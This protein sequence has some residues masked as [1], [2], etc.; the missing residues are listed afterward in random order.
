[1]SSNGV[2]WL[3]ASRPAKMGANWKLRDIAITVSGGQRREV[4][5]FIQLDEC[6][7]MLHV[8]AD[9]VKLELTGLGLG[10]VGGWTFK[11]VE[12]GAVACCTDCNVVCRQL[13]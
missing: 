12:E 3:E 2:G 10:L 13:T 1:M 11:K 6:E 8:H 7:I 4:Q 5:Y 9:D